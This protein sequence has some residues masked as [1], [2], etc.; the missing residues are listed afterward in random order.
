MTWR[1]VACPSC[2]LIG[3]DV[4]QHVETGEV[5]IECRSCQA[6]LLRAG[7][8]ETIRAVAVGPTHAPVGGPYRQ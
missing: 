1:F 8:P 6:V 2:R 4:Q 5:L 7:P 3:F